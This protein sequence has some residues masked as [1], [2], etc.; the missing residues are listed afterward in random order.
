M[1]RSR[2]AKLKR[3]SLT[4]EFNN[5]PASVSEPSTKTTHPDKEVIDESANVN[6]RASTTKMSK[7]DTNF[8]SVKSKNK[9]VTL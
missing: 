8:N 7:A 9:K 3:N 6:E 5:E 2:N 1:T 4:N